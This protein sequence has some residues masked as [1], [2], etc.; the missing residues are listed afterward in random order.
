MTRFQNKQELQHYVESMLND[1]DIPYEYGKVSGPNGEQADFVIPNAVVQVETILDR[2]ALFQ[3]LEQGKIYQNYLQKPR[4]LIFGQ[5]PANPQEYQLVK[6]MAQYMVPEVKVMF[7]EGNG[8]PTQ[9]AWG[10]LFAQIPQ[11]ATE[12]RLTKGLLALPVSRW[13]PQDELTT[14]L[15]IVAITALC[16]IWAG[17]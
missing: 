16:M 5:P 1:L 14:L 6:A 7:V 13:L 10:R 4:L 12:T 3:A 17:R 9:T 11:S 8:H 2:A 15:G